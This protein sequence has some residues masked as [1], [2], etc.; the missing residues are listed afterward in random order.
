MRTAYQASVMRRA[1]LSKQQ[2]NGHWQ[3]NYFDAWCEGLTGYPMIDACMRALKESGWLNF[4]MRAMLVSFAS[5]NLWLHWQPT[6]VYLARHFLDFEPGIH[7]PQLQMQ[8]GT[9]AINQVRV[10]SP[11]KQGR[12]QDPDGCII[13]QDYPAPIV[14]EEA[15]RVAKDKIFQ[16]RKTV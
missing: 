2:N 13:G 8:S 5:Y 4:R 11:S 7:Y 16:L 15:S 3:N 1:Q 10:Y 14:N 9:T 6:A 12:D